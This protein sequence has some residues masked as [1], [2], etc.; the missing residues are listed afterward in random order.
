[1]TNDEEAQDVVNH[2]LGRAVLPA[3]TSRR[4]WPLLALP[5]HDPWNIPSAHNAAVALREWP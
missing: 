3:A 5:R 2:L 4:G 1:V